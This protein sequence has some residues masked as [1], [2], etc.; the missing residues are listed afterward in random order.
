MKIKNIVY[1]VAAALTLGTT[2]VN[3]GDIDV[4]GVVDAG[5]SYTHTSAGNGSSDH[6]FEIDSGIHNGSRIGIKG[7]EKL[8]ET[9]TIGFQ[10]E[11]GFN[12]DSGEFADNDRAFNRESR[13]YITDSGW[14]EVAFGRVGGLDS[15]NGTYGLL[16]AAS[17]F[18]T[19]WGNVG[20]TERVLYGMSRGRY[21]NTITYKSP[22]LNGVTVFAQ[23]STDTDASLGGDESSSNVNRYGAFGIRGPIGSAGQFGTTFAITDYANTQYSSA[24]NDNGFAGTIYAKY[25]FGGIVPTVAV[26]YFSSVQQG[27]FDSDGNAISLTQ[28]TAGLDGVGVVGAV[29][30]PLYGGTVKTQLGYRY[31]EY[32]EDHFAGSDNGGWNLAQAAIG[33]DYSISKRTMLYGGVGYTWEQQHGTWTDDENTVQVVSGVVHKF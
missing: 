9:T 3:A 19:G 18:E 14:G 28:E 25:D 2:S 12:V 8:T 26:Q 22:D 5:V 4:Y 20:A 10:L 17:P 33:Y 11:Q 23:Y 6:D 32:S 31:A 1:G 27:R 13:L 15:G 29:S 21:D 30:F 7:S 24:G 16:S